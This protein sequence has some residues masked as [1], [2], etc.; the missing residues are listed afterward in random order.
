MSIHQA[1]SQLVENH[2]DRLKCV[3]PPQGLNLLQVGH[4]VDDEGAEIGEAVEGVVAHDDHAAHLRQ[5]EELEG[6]A[7]AV[8]LRRRDVVQQVLGQPERR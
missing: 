5:V 4:A 1:C 2:Q 3:P 6:G 8:Q 7:H